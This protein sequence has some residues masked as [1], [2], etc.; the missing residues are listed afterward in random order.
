MRTGV[1]ADGESFDRP[2]TVRERDVQQHGDAID[3][4][5]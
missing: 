1:G 4:S 3:R 2:A 5:T